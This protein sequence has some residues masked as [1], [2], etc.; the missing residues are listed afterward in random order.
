MDDLYST[1][2]SSSE[3]SGLENTFKRLRADGSAAGQKAAN[4]SSLSDRQRLQRGAG[5]D[6]LMLD[7]IF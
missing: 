2:D 4:F 6:S 1:H 5:S 7:G 3:L